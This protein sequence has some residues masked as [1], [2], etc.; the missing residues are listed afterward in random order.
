MKAQ[1][2]LAI[3]EVARRHH[4]GMFLGPE[5]PHQASPQKPQMAAC[6]SIVANSCHMALRLLLKLSRSKWC[7]ADNP[8]G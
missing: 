3:N 4:V 1:Q 2:G 7:Q 8:T 5:H 6:D